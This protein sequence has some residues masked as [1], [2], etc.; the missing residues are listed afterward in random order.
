MTSTK[1]PLARRYLMNRRLWWTA[2]AACICLS[3]SVLFAR[4]GVVKTRDGKTIEGDIEERPDQVVVT[5]RGIKTAVNRDNIEG[6]VEYFDN[7]EA[8]YQDKVSK[9]P[10][11]PTADDHLALARWCFEV[12]QYDLALQEIEKARRIEPNSADAATLEQTVNV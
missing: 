9:L 1:Q 6:Q 10:A 2:A 7:V 5:I 11:K 3:T 12:R 8:R 4:P